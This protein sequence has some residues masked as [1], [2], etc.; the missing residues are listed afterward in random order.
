MDHNFQVASVPTFRLAVHLRRLVD[1]GY[2]VERKNTDREMNKY[3]DIESPFVHRFCS[4]TLGEEGYTR[5]SPAGFGEVMC[6]LWRWFLKPR[7]VPSSLNVEV[8]F[9]RALVGVNEKHWC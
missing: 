2:K 1:A 6:M 3:A 4:H 8:V 7:P 9:Y 5:K